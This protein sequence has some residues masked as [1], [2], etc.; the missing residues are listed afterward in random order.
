[1]EDKGT[2]G[3]TISNKHGFLSSALNAAVPKRIPFNPAASQRLPET[4]K[5]DMVA[6]TPEEF[7]FLLNEI[8][9]YWRPLVEFLVASGCRWG[10]ATALAPSDVNRE[11]GTV[12]ITKVWKRTYD[13]GIGYETGVP[14]TKR[15]IR[16]INV[17]KSVL[18]KLDYS[19][20]FLFTNRAGRPVRGNGFHDRVWSPAVELAELDPKPRIHDLR[21]SCA[22]WMVL[23]GPLRTGPPSCSSLLKRSTDASPR[24]RAMPNG[25]AARPIAA[26]RTRCGPR[27]MPYSSA[28]AP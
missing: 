1:M 3:K 21:H 7:A 20:E 12:R 19:G 23:A 5:Q 15:S 28:W 4:V 13:D 10:E 9:E 25:S 14:K 27:A 24:P 22:T 11:K 16:T 6:L 8:T 2:S 18:D 17:S 26:S